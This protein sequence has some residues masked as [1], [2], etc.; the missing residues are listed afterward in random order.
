MSRSKVLH[1]HGI[2]VTQEQ[3]VGLA[4]DLIEGKH[5]RIVVAQESDDAFDPRGLALVG[6]SH[7]ALTAANGRVDA[8]PLVKSH[9]D[10]GAADHLS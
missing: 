5:V 1:P 8:T 3:E 4:P 9:F 6:W 2:E 7:Y 10:T